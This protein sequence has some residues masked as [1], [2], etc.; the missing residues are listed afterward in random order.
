MIKEEIV[1]RDNIWA[2]YKEEVHRWVIIFLLS[3]ICILFGSG[4]KNI[5]SLEA[6]FGGL[7][8]EY[9]PTH[10]AQEEKSIFDWGVTTNKFR[11]MPALMEMNYGRLR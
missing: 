4:C 7:D 5:K 8:I 11:A 3:I 1:Y 10:P 9:Y 2:R 6:D